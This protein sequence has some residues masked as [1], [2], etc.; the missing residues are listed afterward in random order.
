MTRLTLVF[1][2]KINQSISQFTVNFVK[3]I[4]S[5]NAT[6][7]CEISTIDLSS[8]CSA[9]QIYS[10]DFAKFGCLLRIYEL[11]LKGKCCFVSPVITGLVQ[12]LR[13]TWSDQKSD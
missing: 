10:G 3:F 1:F 7:F 13:A 11:Y 4:Y 2:I 5:E 8:L 12:V 9:C 6:K